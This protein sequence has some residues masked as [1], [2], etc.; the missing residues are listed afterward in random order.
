MNEVL[1]AGQW[2]EPR[3]Y[4]NLSISG[5]DAALDAA[6]SLKTDTDS[7]LYGM[8]VSL[9]DYH[10]DAF[11]FCWQKQHVLYSL[12]VILEYPASLSNFWMRMSE[13]GECRAEEGQEDSWRY[14]GL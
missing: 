8:G 2:Y 14:S 6:H 12:L 3:E 4:L 5:K 9:G 10:D 11:H 1:N 13:P 7:K